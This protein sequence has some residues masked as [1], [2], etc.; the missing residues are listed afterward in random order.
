MMTFSCMF[1]SCEKI[2]NRLQA[3]CH[4]DLSCF[5]SYW[6]KNGCKMFHRLSHYWYHPDDKAFYIRNPTRIYN[7][8][9]EMGLMAFDFVA[10]A[11]NRCRFETKNFFSLASNDVLDDLLQTIFRY[12]E[13]FFPENVIPS[14]METKERNGWLQKIHHWI[15]CNCQS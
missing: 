4:S 5:L 9:Q 2:P 14:A 10:L 7:G 6:K 3:K 11:K 13:Y 15:E 12:F 1:S 8:L